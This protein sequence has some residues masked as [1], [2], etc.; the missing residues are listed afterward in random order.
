MCIVH[1]QGHSVEQLSCILVL[2]LVEAMAGR[3]GAIDEE[4]GE[5]GECLTRAAEL[6]LVGLRG[7]LQHGGRDVGEALLAAHLVDAVTSRVA[8][9]ERLDYTL[10]GRR[11]KGRRGWG[12]EAGGRW[13]CQRIAAV[14]LCPSA[15]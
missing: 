6:A 11:R 3:R 8:D 5:V 1:L 13:K 12:G 7:P 4:P 15:T 14:P 2:M 9:V 10:M